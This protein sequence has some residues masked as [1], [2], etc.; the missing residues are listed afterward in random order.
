MACT[1]ATGSA[2]SAIQGQVRPQRPQPRQ[3]SQPGQRHGIGG[4]QVLEL[5][6]RV[7]AEGEAHADRGQRRD[8]AR[9]AAPPRRRALPA[10]AC[11]K[12]ACSSIAPAYRDANTP[13]AASGRPPSARRRAS[14]SPRLLPRL[15]LS[16][17]PQGQPPAQSR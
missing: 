2:A 12:N 10:S 6:D 5:L 16:P 3:Y 17:G 11:A 1:A 4:G 13:S 15:A 9:P 14:T 7:R 8:V